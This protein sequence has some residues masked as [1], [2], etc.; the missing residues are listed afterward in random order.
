MDLALKVFFHHTTAGHL[1]SNMRENSNE[2]E[3]P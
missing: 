3:T 1:H 2:E